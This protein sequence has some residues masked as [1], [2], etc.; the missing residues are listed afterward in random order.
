MNYPNYYQ[1][2]EDILF[3]L[4]ISEPEDIDLELIASHCGA[5]IEYKPLSSCEA[6]LIGHGHSAN[7]IINSSS[8]PSRKRFS[9]A[10]ELGHWMHDREI[11]KF[12]CSESNLALDWG[13]LNAE[14]RANLY[15]ANLLIPKPLLNE[16]IKNRPP[17]FELILEVANAFRTSIT[18]SAIRVIKL[19]QHNAMLVLNSPDKREWFIRSPFLEEMSI[20]IW[21]EESPGT[22]TNAFKLL[23]GQ[24]SLLEP[25]TVSADNWISNDG[26]GDYEIVEDSISSYQDKV[27]SLLWWEDESQLIDLESEGEDPDDSF[28]PR[29]R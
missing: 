4:G 14:M 16:F 24:T 3:D 7:I 18:S 25:T 13:I 27:L 19:C 22:E 15:A 28:N 20:K 8:H 2:P 9:I 26:S 10:H 17:T 23:N 5:S 11:A 1:S 29:F 21:P 6:C 12:N